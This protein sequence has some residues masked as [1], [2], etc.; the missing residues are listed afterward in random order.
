MKKLFFFIVASL[1]IFSAQAQQPVIVSPEWLHENLNDPDL[2]ILYTGFVIKGDFERE[3]IDGSRFLWPDWLA[4]NSPELSM[5]PV[6]VNEATKVL[7]ELGINKNSKIILCHKGDNV[8]I[9]ARMF[10]SLEY[11]GLQGKVSYLNGGIEA[12]KK[13][14]TPL[15]ANPLFTKEEIILPV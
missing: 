12:W 10:C 11:F 14:D 5:S 7:Q 3:H 1:T 6:D 4:P 13:Q 2:V 9:T 15:P 8:T